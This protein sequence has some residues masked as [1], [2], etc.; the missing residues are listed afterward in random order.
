MRSV[1][2]AMNSRSYSGLI[3]A[4]V[5]PML[6]DGSINV[7]AVPAI[8][9]RLIEDGV[10]GLYVCGSTGEG[11]SLTIGERKSVA[12]AYVQAAAG[13]LPVMVQ[14]GH[15]SLAEAQELARHAQDCG[16]SAVSATCPS[17]FRVDSIDTLVECM[18]EIACGSATLPFFYY[19]IPALTGNQLCMP[20]FLE[21]AG[22]RI[23]NLAGLK[24]T[25]PELHVYQ[26]CQQVAAE[27][28]EI[29]WGTDE[30]LLPA[31]ACGASAAIGSTYNIAAPLY[32]TIVQAF[33]HNELERARDLQLQA[34]QMVAVMQ[35][36][37][38]H[39]AL[40]AVMCMQGMEVGS[41]RWPLPQL[42]PDETSKLESQLRELGFFQWRTG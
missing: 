29:F 22:Q 32:S 16:A 11:V 1:E 8:V 36:F 31:L 21:R 30:M 27:R 4:A 7:T 24:Y 37:P 5:T 2:K 28:F 15:N 14:V 17:Y 35:Q 26:R 9:E 33:E 42:A 18:A 13:R 20:T 41:C 38:F 19:H 23:E 12:E 40:K 39:A 10:R 6:T 3:A 25:T 34:I